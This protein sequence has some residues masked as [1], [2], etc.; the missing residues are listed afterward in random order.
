ML[1]SQVS[2]TRSSSESDCSRN[3]E[4]EF[5]RRRESAS[6]RF[7]PGS[8][9]G[10]GWERPGSCHRRLPRRLHPGPLAQ[11]WQRGGS[12]PDGSSRLGNRKGFGHKRNPVKRFP[13]RR[14]FFLLGGEIFSSGLACLAEGSPWKKSFCETKQTLADDRG[15]GALS[16]QSSRNGENYRE[17]KGTSKKKKKT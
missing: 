15:F 6:S 9:P 11:G 13:R 1:S 2:P 5:G 12:C 4:S 10:W 7:R 8:A 3:R 17:R 16:K 14:R